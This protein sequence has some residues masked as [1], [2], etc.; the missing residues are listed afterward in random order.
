MT[1]PW[2]FSFLSFDLKI[3][4]YT[5]QIFFLVGRLLL[6]FCEEDCENKIEKRVRK[7]KRVQKVM[8]TKN[9]LN[10]AFSSQRENI[11]GN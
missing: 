11:S 8:P 5:F 4:I 3:I 7:R 1:F 2:D 6:H 10:L 9:S